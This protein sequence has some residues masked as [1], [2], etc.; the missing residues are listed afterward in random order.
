MADSDKNILITPSRGLTTQ[1]SI[2]FTGQGNDPISLK[3]LDGTTGTLSFEGSSGQLFSIT[4]NL[5]SGSIFSVNDVSGLPSIDVNANGT[6]S[7]GVYG[8]NIGIGTSSPTSKLQVVGTITATSL[9]GSLSN[10]LTLGTS[11]SGLSG[12]AT[13]NNSGAVTFT[14]TSNATANNTASTL[15]FRDASG[16]FSANQITASVLP[17]TGVTT[18]RDHAV[19]AFADA[20]IYS[21][22]NTED[23]WIYCDAA[24]AQWGIY[25]RNIDSDLV[26]AGQV[27]LP[28]NSIAFVGGNVVR[29]YIGLVGGDIY[30][31]GSILAGTVS[32]SGTLTLSSAT[33]NAISID[34]GTTGG[35]SIGTNANA[36]AIAIG[37]ATVASTITLNNNT[38]LPAGKTLTLSGSTSGTIAL[39][40]TATAGTNTI[41]FPAS[42]GTV[43]LTA[44]NLGVF[45]TTTSAQL[46]GVISDETGSGLLVFGTSPSL[47]T[48]ALS[49]ETFSTSS[50]V[51][52]GTNAQGQGA[53]TSDYNVITTA[54]ANPSGVTLPTAT[55]G[56]R[57]IVVNRGANPVNIYPATGA[58]IDGLAVNTSIQVAINGVLEFNASST[59]QW[60]STTSLSTNAANLTGTIPSA[61]LGN[62]SL[63][64]GTTSIALNRA[65]A[66]QA[67]T[68]IT[69]IDGSA[70]TLTTTR[71]IWG[72]N[73][74]GS[75]NV[76]GSLTSVGDITG[77]GA[78]TL[79][80]ATASNLTLNSG[81]TGVVSIDSGTTGAINIGTN[82]NA[83]TITIGNDTVSSVL[84][85]AVDTKI[86]DVPSS[87]TAQLSLFGKSGAVQREG[88]LRLGGTFHTSADTT[89]RMIASIR[90]GF[91]AATWGNE[92]LDFYINSVAN[93]TASDGNQTRAM[94]IAYGGQVLLTGTT[95][96]ILN[97]TQITAASAR[98]VLKANTTGIANDTGIYQDASNNM[99]LAARDGSG[100]L[101][102]VLDTNNTTGSYINTTAGFSVGKSSVTTGYT[103]LGTNLRVGVSSKAATYSN[104]AG[105]TTI[106]VTCTNH[107]LTSSD[108]VYID[109]TA[110]TA[111]DGYFNQ[112]TVTNSSTFTVTAGAAIAAANTGQACTIYAENQIRF[113]GTFGDGNSS[114]DH[115]VISER[116]WGAGD[117]SELLIFKGNDAGVTIQ[118]NIRL[119]ASGDIYLH[120]GWTGT[121][122]GGYLGS[123][124]N[125]VASATVALRADGNLGVGTTSPGQ[126]LDV[127]GNIILGAQ[128]SG[129]TTTPPYL[130]LGGNFTSTTLRANCKIRLYDDGAGDVYGL[131][132]GN[133][134][135]VQ[136]H[137]TTTHQFYNSNAATCTINATGVTSTGTVQGTRLISDSGAI[138]SASWTTSGISFY[139][140]GRTFTNTTGTGTLT[141]QVANSFGTP[142]FASSS[143]VTVTSA[144]N[145][146]IAGAP[147]ASTN[148]T[149][150][151]S[152]GL[153]VD[154]GMCRF[155]DGISIGAIHAKRGPILTGSLTSGG[156]GYTNGTYTAQALT[157]GRGGGARADIT[158]ISGAVTAVNIINPGA[159]YDVGDVLTASLGTGTGFQWTVGTVQSAQLSVYRNSTSAPVIR[160]SG[161]NTVV[162]TGTELGI[163]AFNSEDGSAGAR[164]DKVK[165]VATAQSS[166]GGGEL[167]IWTSLSS[168]EPQL[169]AEFRAGGDLRLAGNLSTT[170]TSVTL[171]DSVATTVNAFGDATTLNIGYNNSTLAS[172]TNISVY[173][174]ASGNVRAVNIATGGGATGGTTVT[175]GGGSASSVA[176][177]G[178]TNNVSTNLT[179]GTTSDLGDKGPVLSMFAT[180]DTAGSGYREGVN[181]FTTSGGSGSG[182]LVKVAVGGGIIRVVSLTPFSGGYGYAS[183]EVVTVLVPYTNTPVLGGSISGNGTTATFTYTSNPSTLSVTGGSGTGTA[184]TLTF[185]PQADDAPFPIG[186]TITVN[187][188]NLAG[189]NG[190]FTVTACTTSQ[191][192]YSN[193]TTGVFTAGGSITLHLFA[194]NGRVTIAG[195][196]IAGY[197]VTDAT[198]VTS[199]ATGFTYTNATTGAAT[200]ATV[201]QGTRLTDGT[202]QVNSV[203]A[204]DLFITDSFGAKIRLERNDSSIIAND[205]IGGIYFAQKQ[206][207]TILPAN[208]DRA[209]I[210][211]Y[212]PSSGSGDTAIQFYTSVNSSAPE[213]AAELTQSNALRLY[214]S[215]STAY[216]A[217]VFTSPTANRTHTLPDANGTFSL[218]DAAQTISAAKTFLANPRLNDNVELEIG[219][220]IDWELFHDGTNNYCDLNNGDLIIRDNTAARFTFSR[221]SGNLNLNL[222]N[223]IIGTTGSGIDF[224][225][226]A[227]SSGTVASEILSDYEEGTFTPTLAGTTVTGTGTYGIRSGSYTRVG[228]RVFF[229]L[230]MTW[231]AHSG[232]GNMKVTG[233]PFT[234]AILD[235]STSPA[236]VWIT[237]MTLT[238]N[239][240]I[241]AYVLANTSEV[242]LTQVPTGGGASTSIP[243]DTAA[244][245]LV[246]GQY[247]A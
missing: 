21:R 205:E 176:I 202:V 75:A 57:I 66:S 107:G 175:I 167:Q 182:L 30:S 113:P 74:N 124:G 125:T 9:S 63:F 53:L 84:N 213:I 27:T 92:Y 206:S 154:A 127:R 86:E 225:A 183:L 36:K 243:M 72:Q 198:V 219:T 181:I 45:A 70:A 185:A 138:S 13:Y 149:I 173:S 44:N 96:S 208:G 135:D 60:Y 161:A 224:S 118:D 32:S 199:T 81:S 201:V 16:N 190:T 230:Y 159:W 137:S 38:T 148:T 229:N 189:A 88:K 217:L 121:T 64:I 155:D 172:T 216:S 103:D 17:R 152:Y 5:A 143:A 14:V 221:A 10:T 166:T 73:F 179:V 239:N 24:N 19:G 191:V 80:S 147:A 1:P 115:T 67:L 41:T 48:P 236:S 110:G 207:S 20:A 79:S 93:D 226:T 192:T 119:A 61:V 195:A 168:G 52:A 162:N 105:G 146:Y 116:L 85:I 128:V 69:S 35:I 145:V 133:A 184:V 109:F 6:I 178:G 108:S 117:K 54:A 247:R 129:S 31:A 94:R 26:V 193:T 97:I 120:T 227:N 246:S 40:A 8:G 7:L 170:N 68:G 211:A 169:G 153:F 126:K 29:A 141:N 102:I 58:T 187:G 215:T 71:T 114:Y 101:R 76:T 112:V 50:T 87:S 150:T 244:T 56:R 156:S 210:R 157:G 158:V 42:T 43:A 233:L 234:A 140:A 144:S 111:V 89:A 196:S 186:S 203:R 22:A 37:N 204:V 132:I 209:I 4:D 151:D 28:Q 188:V 55:T 139:S 106:T 15:V 95:D 163:I 23:N 134:G 123:H 228:N 51:T 100:T 82:A 59:T 220:G 223:L 3:V 18:Y 218:I 235:A 242:T 83:K 130:S 11:G 237:D 33:T 212:A 240:V 142:T 200:G 91:S 122:Y 197:N 90:A 12:S 194:V 131:G 2:V 65:S 160:I 46:A 78:V 222:G 34:S 99:Q 165:L 62:S 25:H 180:P 214:D 164:G 238:A 171:F 136:Y 47:T 39:Q 104:A 177:N 232:T 241:Q 98:W 77:S 231:S 245:L 49:G 174:P